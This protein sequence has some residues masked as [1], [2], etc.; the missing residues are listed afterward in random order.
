M[1]L[2]TTSRISVQVKGQKHWRLYPIVTKDEL[3]DM[4]LMNWTEVSIDV[5]KNT[6]FLLRLFSQ[7]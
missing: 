3:Q 4:E 5:Y 7:F 6:G 1:D 2:M